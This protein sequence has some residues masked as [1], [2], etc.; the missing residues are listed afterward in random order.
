MDKGTLKWLVLA[1]IAVCGMLGY[2]V[3]TKASKDGKKEVVYERPEPRFGVITAILYCE[4]DPSVL[5]EDQILHEGDLI[6]DVKIVDI[7]SEQVVF[8]KQG[9][10]WDQKVQEPAKPEWWKR[11]SGKES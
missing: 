3:A 11:K 6:H 10:T 8:T 4:D 2:K 7:K 9:D 1:A 5:I